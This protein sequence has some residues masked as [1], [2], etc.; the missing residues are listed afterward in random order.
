MSPSTAPYKTG[1]PAEETSSVEV[2]RISLIF[3]LLYYSFNARMTQLTNIFP[4]NLCLF[5]GQECFLRN[6]QWWWWLGKSDFFFSFSASVLANYS[7]N[8]THLL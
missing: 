2:M 5:K 6:G 4:L 1:R 8:V 7:K 3:F